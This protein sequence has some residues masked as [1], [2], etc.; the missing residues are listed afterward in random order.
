M[1]ARKGPGR[2]FLGRELINIPKIYNHE[3]SVATVTRGSQWLERQ[4]TGEGRATQAV[5]QKVG[6]QGLLS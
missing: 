1:Y 4:V 5:S 2:C 3:R 6:R